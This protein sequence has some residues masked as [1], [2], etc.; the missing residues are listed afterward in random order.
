MIQWLHQHNQKFLLWI[1]P[2]VLGDMAQTAK[3]KGYNLPLMQEVESDR[4][5]IDFTNPDAREWWKENGPGKMMRMGVDGFKLD[6]AE[7]IVPYSR[8]VK[9][10]DGRSAREF[11]NGY[12]VEYLKATYEAA[13]EVHGDDF[14][15]LPRAAYTGSSKYGVFWGGDIASPPEGL[16]CAIIALQRC[17]IMGYP[18][19]GSDIGGYSGGVDREITSRWLGFGCFCPI[20][21]VGPTQ[22]RGLWN[23]EDEPSYDPQLLATWRLYASL[24]N[25]LKDYTY[26][27]AKEAH[28]TGMPVARPLI[29]EYPDQ[30]KAY[31]DWQTFLYGP[32]IL[33]SAIWQKGKTSHTCYL[34]EGDRWVDAWNKDQEYKGGQTVTIKTPVH[35]IPIFIRKGSDVE[36]GDLNQLYKESLNI[37]KE[38]PDIKEL[39]KKAEF[40][41]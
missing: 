6:R 25:R 40:I 16:R 28:N 7:E 41:Q 17:A 14:I 35:K 20:M 33:V 22:D 4:V 15:L 9:A 27:Y 24:H 19:W 13:K 1:A 38:E 5:L 18:F 12:P 32:D 29:M 34:P 26:Q 8:E 21:E 11:R 36:I 2:W 30:E 10:F 31:E 37:T 23:L 39:E 3:E